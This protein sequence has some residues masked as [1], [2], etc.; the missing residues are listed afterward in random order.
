M[1]RRSF[2][3]RRTNL[4]CDS[5]GISTETFTILGAFALLFAGSGTLAAIFFAL[6]IS[7]KFGYL[8]N[9]SEVTPI[10]GRSQQVLFGYSS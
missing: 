7:E 10:S 9:D 6:F 8:R 4:R 2:V 3:A 1:L 5:M